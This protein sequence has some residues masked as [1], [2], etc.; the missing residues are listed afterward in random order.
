[1]SSCS[2]CSQDGSCE[3]CSNSSNNIYTCVFDYEGKESFVTNN[4]EWRQSGDKKCPAG[5]VEPVNIKDF[6]FTGF[7]YPCCPPDQLIYHR[8]N[9]KTGY[10]DNK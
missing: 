6:D 7:E 5:T 1:M 8:I 10:C 3:G 2:C 4:V 9:N